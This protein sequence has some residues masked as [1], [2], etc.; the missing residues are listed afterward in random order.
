MVETEENGVSAPFGLGYQRIADRVVQHASIQDG[1]IVVDVGTGTG[2]L[3]FAAFQAVGNTGKVIA[4]DLDAGCIQR[5]RER[6]AQLNLT[7]LAFREGD[8]LSLPVES[9]HA[10]VVL[11]RS[12]LCHI[13]D[14]EAAVSQ[15]HRVLKKSG[16]FSLYEPIDRY[17]TRFSDLV[18]FSALGETADRLREAEEALHRNSN[19]PLMNF[20][21]VELKRILAATGFR[22]IEY[23]MVERSREYEMT[24]SLARTW[25]HKD[26]GGVSLPGHDSPYEVLGQYLPG[27]DLDACV[28]FFCSKLNNRSI[29]FESKQVYMWGQK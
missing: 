21:E 23:H 28:D 19:D 5:C 20:D 6:A 7:N 22:D 10:D 29:T 3:A 4:V 24:S 13:V 14:K 12:V 2:L 15:W 1:D 9:N 8:A 27:K 26:I 25:W 17:D 16:R 11:S 18:D